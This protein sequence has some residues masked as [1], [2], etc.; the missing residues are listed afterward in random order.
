MPKTRLRSLSVS[1]FR[2]IHTPQE[3]SLSPDLTV[4]VGR[5]NVGKSAFLHAMAPQQAERPGRDPLC[6]STRMAWTITSDILH[7]YLEVG[8]WYVSPISDFL[9]SAQEVD[10]EFE[11][12]ELQPTAHLRTAQFEVP[13]D[14][15]L[16]NLGAQSLQVSSARLG[17]SSVSVSLERRAKRAP[18]QGTFTWADGTDPA[19]SAMPQ[20][21]SMVFALCQ[22]LLNS[23]FYIGPLRAPA[24]RV[25]LN[26][27]TQLTP[28]GSNLTNVLADLYNN[29][30]RTIY[31]KVEEFV[32]EA[33][34]EIAH[35]DIDLQH[36]LHPSVEVAIVY[37]G[38][39]GDRV[40]L[41]YCG[42]GIE[43][44][45][46]LAVAV[47]ATPSAR[48][49]LID[50]PH[51]YLHPHAERALLR[52][53]S[54]HPGKQYTVATHS[55]IFIAAA[56]S[57]ALYLFKRGPQGTEILNPATELD[58]LSELGVTP[59]HAW[60]SEAILWVEGPTEVGIFDVIG[61]YEPS[62]LAG[63][64]IESMPS[65]LRAARSRPSELGRLDSMIRE[66]ARA[67]SPFEARFA[68]LFD[69]DEIRGSARDEAAGAAQSAVRFLPCRE[70]EN[71]LMHA[72]AIA[73]LISAKREVIGLPSVALSEVADS[74]QSIL[75]DTSNRDLYP[76]GATTSDPVAVK[77]SRVL[78]LVFATFDN[79]RYDKVVDGAALATLV[80]ELAPDRLA[81]LRE[82]LATLQAT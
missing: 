77:G 66:I 16:P 27:A 30:R 80:L 45:L 43:Q 62:L 63:I 18:L 81:P 35:V 6:F 59:S 50:E 31:P 70:V 57:G 79:L 55:P 54:T 44:A 9:R 25:Q 39:S 20:L 8:H 12:Q 68:L 74:L 71:L 29:H 38:P 10:F 58:I 76:G 21:P 32:R 69:R 37:P 78:E 67:L 5:N 56:R 4:L 14:S 48:V 13:G 7:T 60:A 22:E 2:S 49:L 11:L 15:A 82:V 53:L 1:G 61:R 72:G 64:S 36:G 40:P 41:Q 24:P 51:A 33:F 65:K 73:R 34:P 19:L 46:L 26:A 23:T 42:T 3:L 17:L 75:A 47:L 52:L 28:D